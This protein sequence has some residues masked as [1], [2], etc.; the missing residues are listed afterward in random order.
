MER[1]LKPSDIKH[2]PA[3]DERVHIETWIDR[4]LR[5]AHSYPVEIPQPR[6]SWSPDNLA[7]VL[8][9]YAEHWIVTTGAGAPAGSM[10]A[11]TPRS[12]P[13]RL[14]AVTDE[15][16]A[17]PILVA[18]APIGTVALSA[19]GRVIGKVT[20][21]TRDGHV[22][23]LVTDDDT[24]SAMRAGRATVATLSIGHVVEPEGA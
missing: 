18:R 19:D 2:L 13:S 24:L 23:V 7:S 20:A 4:H 11:L 5:N 12:S 1:M 17:G 15:R 10:A 16:S 21:H 8:D 6:C 22:T 3:P 14:R 9:A